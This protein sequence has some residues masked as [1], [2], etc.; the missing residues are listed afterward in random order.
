MDSTDILNSIFKNEREQFSSK[1]SSFTILDIGTI[2]EVKNGRALVHG[3]TFTGGQQ[4][5]YKDAEIVYPG[6][7]GGAYTVEGAG[8]PCLIFIPMSCM[9]DT[10]NRKVQLYSPKYNT[11][12]VK[13]MPIGN[14]AAALVKTCFNA[15]GTYSILGG[16]YNVSFTENTIVLERKDASASL[17]MDYKGGL[18]VIKTGENSTH[19]IDMVDGSTKST[20]QSKDKDVQWIDTLNSDGSRTFVQNNPQNEEANPLFSLTIAKDGTV[21]L[22]GAV[23][24]KLNVTGDAV[25]TVDGDAKINADN[26]EL[27]GSDKRLV[28]YAELKAA[29]DKLWIAMTTTP[30]AGNGSTQPSWTGITS[31]DISASETQTVKT[32]G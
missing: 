2:V 18:H 22:T 5:I 11:D 7:E 31:I 29:M 23:T 8:T 16:D 14:A 28:T 1:L 17:A 26:I 10:G 27:N 25:V 32:G 15:G 30:I 3:S 12:G 6:N 4:A 9:T 24:E 13:V 19:Y 21:T 20:W